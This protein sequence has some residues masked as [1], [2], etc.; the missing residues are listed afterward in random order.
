MCGDDATYGSGE[1]AHHQA[2]STG[3]VSEVSDAFKQIA[4]GDAGCCEENV[5]RRDQVV[6]GE[7]AVEIQPHVASTIQF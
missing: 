3:T 4:G 1:A 2:V 7:Y 5:F 6:D